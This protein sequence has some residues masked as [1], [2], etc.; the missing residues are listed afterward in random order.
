VVMWW[1]WVVSL[2]G[3]MGGDVAGLC[4]LRGVVGRRCR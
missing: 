2:G 1:V 4:V 3:V